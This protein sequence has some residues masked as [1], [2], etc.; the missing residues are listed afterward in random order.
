MRAPNSPLWRLALLA[1]VVIT[2]A[3][4]EEE[5]GTPSGAMCPEDSTLT[6]DSFGKDFMANYCTRCHA[7]A[8]KG[9]AR[10]GAPNDHNFESGPLVRLELDHIDKAAA[11]GPDAINTSMPPSAPMPTEEERRKLGEWVACGAP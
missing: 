8:V 2:A 10:Q 4:Q 5:E 7:V 11:A 3:C 6:W 1:S 9:S